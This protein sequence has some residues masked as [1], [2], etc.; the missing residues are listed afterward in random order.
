MY[1]LS[2]TLLALKWLQFIGQMQTT[3]LEDGMNKG[4]G[5]TRGR[6][7]TNSGQRGMEQWGTRQAGFRAAERWGYPTVKGKGC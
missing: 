7:D 5:D 1:S 6:L 2:K 3:V 4:A